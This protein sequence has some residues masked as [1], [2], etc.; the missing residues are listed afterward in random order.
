MNQIKKYGTLMSV[1]H[2]EDQTEIE[3]RFKNIVSNTR[4]FNRG[5]ITSK[6]IKS[7][8]GETVEFRRKADGKLYRLISL[9]ADRYCL[10]LNY[11]DYEV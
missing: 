9:V 10:E 11:Q 2:F 5:Y 3:R 8:N 4:K 6:C 1:S 7:A